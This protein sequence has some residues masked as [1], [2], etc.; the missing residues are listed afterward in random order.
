MDPGDLAAQHTASLSLTRRRGGSRVRSG[1]G[2]GPPGLGPDRVADGPCEARPSRPQTQKIP[3]S[4]R[5]IAVVGLGLGLVGLD[6]PLS[7]SLSCQEVL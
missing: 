1:S 2:G 7:R 4:L 6:G 3:D 5:L